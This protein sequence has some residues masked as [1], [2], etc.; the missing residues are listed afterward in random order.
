M[1]RRPAR[2]PSDTPFH[3]LALFLFELRVRQRVTLADLAESL[4]D[5]PG[6]SASA[7]SR[8]TSG[9]VLPEWD[10]VKAYVTACGGTPADR[11]KARAEW[12]RARSRRL[13]RTPALEDIAQPHHL[14]AALRNLVVRSGRTQS[15]LL[16]AGV[17]PAF[18]RSTLS[19][20]LHDGQWPKL[21]L[22]MAIV[23]ACGQP[24]SEI[25]AWEQAWKRANEARGVRTAAQVGLGPVADR[26]RRLEVRTAVLADLVPSPVRTRILRRMVHQLVYDAPELFVT[27]PSAQPELCLYAAGT[28]HPRR[29]EAA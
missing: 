14:L 27:K 5:R 3:D 4:A 25:M 26:I 23:R 29:D 22:V 12:D 15:D 20:V 9:R 24:D 11:C 19:R 1:G 8:F 7:L 18:S 2:P 10:Q 16:E 21:G 17:A 6:F 28:A 13:T